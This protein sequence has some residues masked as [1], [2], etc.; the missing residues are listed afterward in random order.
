MGAYTNWKI[1]TAQKEILRQIRGW[2]EYELFTMEICYALEGA[3][4][5]LVAE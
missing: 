2:R 4:E 5:E 1:E 3:A